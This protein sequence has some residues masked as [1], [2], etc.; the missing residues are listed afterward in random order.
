MEFRLGM[1]SSGHPRAESAHEEANDFMV[2][3]PMDSWMGPTGNAACHGEGS[4]PPERT[5]ATM[6]GIADR[7]VLKFGNK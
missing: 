3:I 5:G 6:M 1:D 7:A 2:S 4:C